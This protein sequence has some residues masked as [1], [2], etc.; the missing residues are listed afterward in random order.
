MWSEIQA[1]GSLTAFKGF[2]TSFARLV[3]DWRAYYDAAAPQDQPL[4]GE[5]HDK[6]NTFQY[7]CALRCLRVD[8]VPDAIMTYVIEKQGQKYVE[9]P[10]FHLPSCYEDSTCTTPLIFVL[11]KGS[12]P[13]KSFLQF[14]TELKF[15]K[16]LSS[17]S[18]GQGQGVKAKKMI[19][20]GAVK[21]FWVFL[22]NCHLYISWM[23]ELERMCEELTPETTHKDFRLWLTSMPSE[24]FPVSV[25]QNGVKMINE[26]PKGLKSNL[27]SAYF[28]ITDEELQATTK[29]EVWRKLLFGMRFFHAVAQERR[30]F[31]PLGWNRP[32]EFND[33]D[34]DVR[35]ND[36]FM[37]I[38]KYKEVK[39][40]TFCPN[41][42]RSP[43]ASS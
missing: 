16:K 22:Q 34:V 24:K 41:F 1:L 14:A 28:K 25:L 32:Y 13:T 5:W 27:K 20:D 17:L 29:P 6:L 7:L 36:L 19:E 8:K 12:D 3:D 21:G 38:N 39:N 4:P 11:S 10:P 2:D 18:L 23:T 37:N 9:P 31:G 15:D 42:I 35:I 43:R 26:P 40:Y 33:T 30:K